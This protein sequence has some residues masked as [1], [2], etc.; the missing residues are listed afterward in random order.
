MYEQDYIIRIITHLIQFLAKVFFGKDTITYELSGDENHKESDELHKELVVL[1]SSGKI[2]E[3]ENLLFDK[4]N[5]EDNR[6]I[7]V[8]IDFYQRLN[9]LDE[10]FLQE[11]DFSR[12]EIEE[13]LRDIASKAGIITSILH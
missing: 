10:E 8:A 5:P 6:H 2:N 1:L 9:E 13:G 3:A 11:H 7:M 12:K 4:L